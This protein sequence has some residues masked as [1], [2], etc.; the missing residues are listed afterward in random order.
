MTTSPRCPRS[1]TLTPS[2][3][4]PIIGAAGPTARIVD[5]TLQEVA[6]ANPVPDPW[7]VRLRRGFFKVLTADGREKLFEV[8]G[9]VAGDGVVK[10]VDINV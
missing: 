9:A 1:T 4:C 7:G 6:T 5:A 2:R 3:S 8:T 10:D